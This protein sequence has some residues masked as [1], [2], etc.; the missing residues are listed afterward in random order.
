MK[1]FQL[2]MYLHGI[3]AEFSECETTIEGCELS[4]EEV[5]VMKYVYFASTPPSLA[6]PDLV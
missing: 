2:G 6:S 5:R 3:R 1:I 4:L